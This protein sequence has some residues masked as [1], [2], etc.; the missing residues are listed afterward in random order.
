M[1]RLSLLALLAAVA[2]ACSTPFEVELPEEPRLVIESLFAADSLLTLDIGL[3]E[4]LQRPAPGGVNDVTDATV[5]LYEDGAFVDEAVYVQNRLRYVSDV[6]PRAGRTYRVRVEAPGFPPAEA[7]ETVPLPRPFTVEVERGPA[8]SRFDDRI[9]D[10]TVRFEDPAGP[11]YYALYGLVERRLPERPD[12]TQ[13]F[14]LSFRSAD[15]AL[16]DGD[17]EALLG[18]TDNPFYV[19]AFFSDRPFEGS[20]VEVLLRVRRLGEESSGQVETIDRLRLATLSETY[21]RYQRA[22]AQGQA[23]PFGEPVRIPSNV[24]GGY[25]IFAAFAASERVLPD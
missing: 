20:A 3:S 6:V 4:P 22:L 16:A 15:P 12:A 21:Y 17:L 11:D 23:N 2:S 14:P 24:E 5:L 13:F 8:R 19:Q 7:E 1:R 10:V 18:E 9:D 25:G